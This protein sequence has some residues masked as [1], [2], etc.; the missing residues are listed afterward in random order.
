M[1]NTN[2]IIEEILDLD[3]ALLACK[4]ELTRAQPPT[5]GALTINFS[6][7][8]KIREQYD[9]EPMVVRFI[10]AADGR[11]MV[12]EVKYEP[13]KLHEQRAFGKNG[14]AFEQDGLVVKLLNQIDSLLTIRSEL[15]ALTRPIRQHAY[16]MI[17]KSKKHRREASKKIDSVSARIIYDWSDP[18]HSAI[19]KIR[20]NKALKKASVS[21][22]Q[23]E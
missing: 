14:K 6:P 13:G 22:P 19:E 16:G 10:L 2:R 21:R 23:D 1:V 4:R 8:Q 5:N 9:V 15:V 18:S 17:E 7:T 12:R 11:W 20:E 3:Y